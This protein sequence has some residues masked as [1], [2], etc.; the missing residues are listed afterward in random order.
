MK[1]PRLRQISKKFG[2]FWETPLETLQA[3]PRDGEIRANLRIDSGESPD[4]RG[5]SRGSRTES[6]FCESRF[7]GLKIANRRFEAIRANR[8]HVSENPRVHKIFVRN[9]GAGNGCANLMGTWKN[10]VLSAGKP[11]SIK[12]L[13]LRGVFCDFFFLGGGKCRF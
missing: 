3:S 4:S 6:L 1:I 11:M 10:C 12:F 9:S 8:S 2:A 13:V 5:S 7:G